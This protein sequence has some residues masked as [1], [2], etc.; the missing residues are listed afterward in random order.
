[1]DQHPLSF[2]HPSSTCTCRGTRER[3]SAG[4]GDFRRLPMA[5]D[6]STGTAA[7]A[8]RHGRRSPRPSAR[9][10]QRISDA[11]DS[12]EPR[13]RRQLRCALPRRRRSGCYHHRAVRARMD[14]VRQ[15]KGR[16][17]ANR[18]VAVPDTRWQHRNGR[19][20]PWQARRRK[21]SAPRR[22]RTRP[23][24]QR[25]ARGARARRRRAPT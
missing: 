11:L 20:A 17:P 16:P 8:K 13:A 25:R 2:G 21:G 23:R 4:K 3:W 10:G 9:H 7:T 5:M 18:R 1:M 19:C 14:A 12:T 22:I 24:R 15:G 6:K